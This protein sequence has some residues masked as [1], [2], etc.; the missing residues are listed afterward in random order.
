ML[1]GKT[2]VLVTHQLNVLPDVDRIIFLKAN[3]RGATIAEMGVCTSIC[4]FVHLFACVFARGCVRV[5]RVWYMQCRIVYL[6]VH[7]VKPR[8]KL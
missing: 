1:H 3:G 7:C 5:L 8:Y 2:R 4:V 6:S